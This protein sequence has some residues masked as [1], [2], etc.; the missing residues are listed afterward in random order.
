MLLHSRSSKKLNHSMVDTS[1]NNKRITKNTIF[2]YIRM[3]FVLIIN[4]YTSRVLLN[5]LG[6]E[7]YGIYNVVAGF[8]AL[9]GFS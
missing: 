2:L 3:F 7:D 8:V 5:A 1:A 9:F 6:V 4:L